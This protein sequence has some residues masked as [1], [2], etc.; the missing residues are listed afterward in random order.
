MSSRAAAPPGKAKLTE[1][2]GPAAVAPDGAF[3]G[4]DGDSVPG[5]LNAVRLAGNQAAGDWLEWRGT[6]LREALIAAAAEDIGV[7]LDLARSPRELG[8][9]IAGLPVFDD[10]LGC[11]RDT[12]ADR[13]RGGLDRVKPRQPGTGGTAAVAAQ[14]IRRPLSSPPRSTPQWPTLPGVPEP[15]SRTG[16]DG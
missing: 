7:L 8:A 10:A 13:P 12:A 14:A 3:T 15:R 9:A 4:P 1:L 2:L 6:E 11:R 5:A 16:H